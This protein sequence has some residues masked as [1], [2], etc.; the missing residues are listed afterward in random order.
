M[1]ALYP[2]LAQA[3]SE[4]ATAGWLV[5]L[6]LSVAALSGCTSLATKTE[7]GNSAQ[8]TAAHQQHLA[9]ID[10]LQDFS[11][12]GRMGVQTDGR[13]VSGSLHW[14]HSDGGG[15][16]IALFSPMGSKIA[17]VK[18][19]DGQVTLTANDGKTYH[20][21]DAETLTEQTLGWRLPVTH[22]S[23]WVLG[24]PSPGAITQASWDDSG[25]LARLTQ[26]GWEIQ[27]QEYKQV[28]DRQPSDQQTRAVSLPSKLT[29]RNPKLYL[30]L[31]IE[32]WNL[33][34]GKQALIPASEPTG[35][36]AQS[37]SAAGN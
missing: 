1:P 7:N 35:P 36:D 14:Q 22:L 33:G 25:Q 8:G 23:D 29:L 4:R 18:S 21:S 32:R 15:D 13:G 16:A 11:L 31:V 12:E 26:D 3:R 27:Y 34:G 19:S 5:V 6:A 20:A 2:S 17:D 24:R 37:S 30:K 9:S 10:H 28:P